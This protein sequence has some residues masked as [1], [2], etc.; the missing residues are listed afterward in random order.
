MTSASVMRTDEGV[1]VSVGNGQLSEVHKQD[2][3]VSSDPEK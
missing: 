3:H 2:R 1:L